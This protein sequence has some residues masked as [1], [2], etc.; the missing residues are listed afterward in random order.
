ML[1]GSAATETYGDVRR[2]ELF[3]AMLMAWLAGS[4]HGLAV[5]GPPPPGASWS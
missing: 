4:G 2:R 5:V 1:S 3:Q